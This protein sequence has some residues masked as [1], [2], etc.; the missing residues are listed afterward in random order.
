M[1]IKKV[2]LFPLFIVTW[3]LGNIIP[4]KKNLILFCGSDADSYNES[5]RY[6]YEYLSNKDELDAV[7]I[8]NRKETV[9]FLKSTKRKV[10]FLK[11]I[12]GIFHFIRAGF[13]IGTGTSYPNILGAVGRKTIKICIHHG[14]GPRSTNSVSAGFFKSP[15]PLIKILHEFNYFNFPSKLMSIQMGKLQFLLPDEK[16]VTLGYPRCDHLFDK[17]TNRKKLLNKNKCSTLI[18]SLLEKDKV[19]LYSPTWRDNDLSM[20]FPISAID[21]FNL[22][23]FN[24]FLQDQHTYLLI[25][26]HPLVSKLEDFS[27][28]KQ[29]QYISYDPLFDINELLPEIDLLITDYSSIATDFMLL[30]RPVIYVMPDYDYFLYERG[31]LEDMR[32]SLAGKEAKNMNELF[33]FIAL[34]F[35]SPKT[36]EGKRKY[37]LSKY[38]D[39]KIT[40][41]CELFHNF[42][43]SLI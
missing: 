29:I 17:V 22:S 20:S 32:K 12:E 9:N 30:D 16:R 27:K 18:P 2:Y 34:Y 21:G 19:I 4:K 23:S 6:L 37:Y 31:L 15:F 7:W 24:E 28:Y 41:S 3:F 14:S 10:I 26:K 25:S 33:E 5:T 43:K 40:N 8:S 42:I 36:D 11:S 35:R 1:T 39:T 13:V 38:Y